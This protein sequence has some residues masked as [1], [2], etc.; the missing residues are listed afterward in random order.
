MKIDINKIYHADNAEFTPN[1]PDGFLDVILEDPPYLYLKNQKLDRPF[2]ELA[3]F[4]ECHRMLREGGF[5]VLFGRGESFY[6]WNTILA[7]LGFEFKEEVVWDKRLISSPLLPMGRRHELISIFCKGKGKINRVK[8]PL[9]EKYKFEPEKIQQ[10]VERIQTT[11]GN[12]KSFDLLKQYYETGH[13][14][15]T[16]SVSSKHNATRSKEGVININRTVASA[17]GLEEG[18]TE[19]SIIQEVREHYDTIH[20][21]QKPPKLLE[22]LLA[23]VITQDKPRN[24]IKIADF[25]GGSCNTAKACITMGVNYIITEIDKEYFALG[26]ENVEIFKEEFQFKLFDL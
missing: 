8:V 21:T 24:Q 26:V 9:L 6:R 4:T 16:K 19:Q 7:N 15:Y 13:K 22:R 3:H 11:F 25:F 1:I 18:I 20:P 10:V 23:L 5:I 12:R 14:E 2:D 17:M